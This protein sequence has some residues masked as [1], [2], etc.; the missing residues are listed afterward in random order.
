MGLPPRARCACTMCRVAWPRGPGWLVSM[1]VPRTV[2]CAFWG[3]LCSSTWLW[4]AGDEG[5]KGARAE[6]GRCTGTR[7]VQKAGLGA[8][9]F[10]G[11]SLGCHGVLLAEWGR[12]L[13]PQ[14]PISAFPPLLLNICPQLTIALH[15]NYGCSAHL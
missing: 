10:G 12:T 2:P 3:P 11:M 5:S 8:C 7:E 9:S 1:C 15:P 6:L 13:I 14:I 4:G